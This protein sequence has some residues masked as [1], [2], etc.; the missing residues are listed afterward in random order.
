VV[1]GA[2]EIEPTGSTEG[3]VEFVS[4]P[5]PVSSVHDQLGLHVAPVGLFLVLMLILMCFWKVNKA[6]R[7]RA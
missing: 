5:I 7:L 2:D 4:G 3:N 6:S 1:A